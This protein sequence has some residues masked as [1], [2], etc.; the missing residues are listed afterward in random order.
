MP[1]GYAEF[2]TIAKDDVLNDFDCPLTK[3]ICKYYYIKY[4][5]KTKTYSNEYGEH[6]ETGVFDDVLGLGGA[7][8]NTTTNTTEDNKS[9]KENVN[10]QIAEDF[11]KNMSSVVQKNCTDVAN[12][13]KQEMI[14]EINAKNE[15]SVAGAK[16]EGK[17][18]VKNVTQSND[19]KSEATMTAENKA[20]T[21]ITTSASNTTTNQLTDIMKDEKKMG[22]SISAV[23]GRAIDAAAGIANNAIDTVGDVT[24]NAVNATAG[25]ATAAIDATAGAADTLMGKDTNTETNTN[26]TNDMTEITKNLNHEK[27]SEIIENSLNSSMKNNVN[28]TTLQAC[29]AKIAADNTIN[30]ENIEAK[31]GIELEN[32][33]QENLITS[34]IDCQFSNEVCNEIV[35]DFMNTVT[36]SEEFQKLTKEEQEGFGAAI[37]AAAEGVG[38]GMATAAVGVGEGTS[39]A[40][41]G[42]GEGA[43]S[44]TEGIGSMFGSMTYLL[45]GCCIFLVIGILGFTKMGG[46]GQAANAAKTV[47]GF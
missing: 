13:S 43:K 21:K 46:I 7:E 29:G 25:V 23:A 36:N 2:N 40:A 19:V 28:T 8:E 1:L 31:E 35:T 45:I 9:Y 22:E 14:V 26:V 4:G 34:V 20:T 12:E 10:K 5:Y 47:K 39:T 24:N 30:L 27:N 44:V 17:F 32:I 16:T 6:V 37:A 15:V 41:K 38:T 18:V 3:G 42:M 33:E 11:K